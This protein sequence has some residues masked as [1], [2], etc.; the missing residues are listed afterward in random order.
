MYAGQCVY[1]T[2]HDLD[3]MCVCAVVAVLASVFTLLIISCDRFFGI[4]FAMKARI[5]ER[6]SSLCIV[7]VWLCAATLAFPLLVFRNQ[8]SRRWLDF[9][10][11]LLEFHDNDN[12]NNE[13]FI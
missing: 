1:Y 4:V 5:T 7:A 2:T 6:R 11:V 3:L 13:L 9:E 12:N 10:E 8:H